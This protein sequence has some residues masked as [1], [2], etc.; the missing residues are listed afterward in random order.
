[1]AVVHMAYTFDDIAF[2]QYLADKITIG[3]TI[4]FSTLYHL[5]IQAVMERKHEKDR[6]LEYIRYNDTWL[7]TTDE[8]IAD[9][10]QWYLLIPV[11]YTHLDVYKR[12]ELPYSK[13]IL[14]D[15]WSRIS[16]EPICH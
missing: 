12:Q 10:Y 5:A 15:I 2:H 13:E 6:L 14:V 8:D 9:A 11:S 1:M 4:D 16:R 7:E 3:L